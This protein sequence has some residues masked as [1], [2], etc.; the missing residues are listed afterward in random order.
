MASTLGT[1]E[2]Y[3]EQD[4]VLHARFDNCLEVVFSTNQFVNLHD[5]RETLQVLIA[6]TQDGDSVDFCAPRLYDLRTAAAPTAVCEMLASIN[7]QT[8]SFRWEVDRR[9]G[10]VRGTISAPLA[11]G[12]LTHGAFRRLLALMPRTVDFGRLR[13]DDRPE[14]EVHANRQGCRRGVKASCPTSKMAA[15]SLGGSV[16]QE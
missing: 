12:A 5:G 9:D 2:N 7:F 14:E 10:E 1:L 8:R 16:S 3:L 11:G 6:V 4:D 13:V 15:A